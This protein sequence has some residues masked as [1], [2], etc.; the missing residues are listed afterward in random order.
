MIRVLVVDDHP[1]VRDGLCG[2]LAGEEDIEVVGEAAN[3]AEAVAYLNQLARLDRV[4][5]VDVVL[6]D[7]RM[8]SMG[9]VEAI[10]E[11]RQIDPAIR[12]LVLTTFDADRDVLPAIEAGATGYLLKDTPGEDL[13]TRH[14]RGASRRGRSVAGGCRSPDAPYPRSCG[15]FADRA[16]ARRAQTRRVGRDQPRDRQ[17]AIHQ[18]DDRQDTSAAPLRQARGDATARRRS[19]PV[20][21]AAYCSRGGKPPRVA[22]RTTPP[23]APRETATDRCARP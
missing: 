22:A 16:G 20:T 17:T 7:L 2:V 4:D 19:R 3:G 23:A 10:R 14:P 5:R 18:R 13:R 21:R 12:I 6:M 1:V 8:P 11:L 9:G 15:R